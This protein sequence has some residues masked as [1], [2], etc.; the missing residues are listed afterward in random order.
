MFEEV[1]A[2][3]YISLYIHNLNVQNMEY[4]SMMTLF[5]KTIVKVINYIFSNMENLYLGHLNA[6]TCI[7]II[8]WLYCQSD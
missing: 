6:S 5:N 2:W 7:R 1:Q 8:I 3:Q 4:A